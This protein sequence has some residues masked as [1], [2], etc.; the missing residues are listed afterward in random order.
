MPT[1]DV[2]A[3]LTAAIG[4]MAT[5]IGILWRDHL[6]SDRE[7][8]QQRDVAVEGWQAATKALLAR[9]RRDEQRTRLDDD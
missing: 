2:V 6:R 7:D 9:N 8:R 4:G 3:L 1:V 5:V